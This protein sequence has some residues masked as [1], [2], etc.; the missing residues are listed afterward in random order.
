MAP[1]YLF[2][3]FLNSIGLQVGRYLSD[4]KKAFDFSADR[5]LKEFDAS[6]A[7]LQ[8]PSVDIVQIH[9]FEFCQDPSKISS[10]TLEAVRRIQQSGKAR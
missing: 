6:L 3:V 10:E 5:V 8:L 2:L 9:D 1:G 4:W 7:R